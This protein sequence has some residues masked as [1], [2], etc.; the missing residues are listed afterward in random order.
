M[1]PPVPSH[2]TTLQ[3]PGSCAVT[4]VLCRGFMVPHRLPSQVLV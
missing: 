2:T 3:S 1:I 4:G